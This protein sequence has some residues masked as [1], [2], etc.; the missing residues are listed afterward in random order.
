MDSEEQCILL[1]KYQSQ[2]KVHLSNIGQGAYI[3]VYHDK[4][5]SIVKYPYDVKMFQ[6]NCQLD[7]FDRNKQRENMNSFPIKYNIPTSI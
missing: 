3:V 1:L 5:P 7:V 2:P 6:L 4:Q